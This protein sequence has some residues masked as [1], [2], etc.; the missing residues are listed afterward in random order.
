MTARTRSLLPLAV[1]LAAAAGAVAYAYYGI[2]RRDDAAQAKKEADAK[3]YLFDPLKVTAVT[4]EAKGARTHL[5][6]AGEGWRIDAPVAADAERA[7]VDALVDDV[8]RLRRKSSVAENPDPAALATYGLASPRAKVTLA[9]DGGK[10]ESLALGDDSAF[11]GSVFVRTT[12]G[13][14]ELVAGSVKYALERG[15]FDLREKR[16][17]P[18]EEKDV[19]RVE[20]TAPGGAYAL[21]RDGDAW[22]LDAPIED[23]ADPAGVQ[24]VL[25]AIRGLRA[26]DFAKAGAA[27]VRALERPQW[28]VKLV[29]A[30]GASRT[31]RLARPRAARGA[32]PE[33]LYARLEGSA[34]VAKVAEGV[35][36]DLDPG[37]AALR[38][39]AAKEAAA[40]ASSEAKTATTGAK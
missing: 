34:E 33:A 5:V 9:V 21:T 12:S 23:K 17:L 19:A 7:T 32:Q 36:K 15:T 2:G 1:L 38:A 13:A 6:R 26:T 25:S 39:K 29:D 27:A 24:R 35:E 10:L 16:L 11:D 4:V 31:L 20:I 30:K 3:L 22:R 37:V 18:L 8:A 28:T 40:P 14:V